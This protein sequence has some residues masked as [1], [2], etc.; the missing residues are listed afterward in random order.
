M[1]AI[2]P[3]DADCFLQILYDEDFRPIRTD[4][5]RMV[6]EKPG[7]APALIIRTDAQLSHSEIIDWLDNAGISLSRFTELRLKHCPP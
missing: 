4:G 1:T 2:A 7:H 6:V 5:V 3:I